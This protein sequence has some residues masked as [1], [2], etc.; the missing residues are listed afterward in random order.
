ME[1]TWEKMQRI[2]DQPI[3]HRMCKV[4]KWS[5]PPPFYY[6]LNSDG[7]C[8]E[9]AYGPGGVIRDC[10][11]TLV[12]AYSMYLGQGMSNRAEGHAMLL[13]LQ[14]CISRG[15]DKTIVE[16]DSKVLVSVVN[17]ESS[18]LWRLLHIVDKIK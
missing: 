12:M 7:S 4:V 3:T 16:A 2:I 8:V 18:T 13:G 5:R 10:N 14:Y 17:E 11:E 1:T 15:L 6:K 9:G